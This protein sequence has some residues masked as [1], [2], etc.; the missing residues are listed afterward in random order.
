[1]KLGLLVASL[2]AVLVGCQQKP[3]KI[4]TQ[5]PVIGENITA[6]RLMKDNPVIL[7][8]RPSFEFNLAHVPGAINVRWEDFSQQNP[9][10]RGLLQPDLFALARRLSLIGVDPQTKV[11]VLG[12]GPQG[13][14]EEGRVA[15]TLKVLGVKEVYTVLHTSYREMN[16]TKEAPLVQNKPY[17]K[18]DVAETLTTDFKDF[19][20][21][22]SKVD[23]SVV[24]I[25]VRSAQEYALRNLSQIKDVKASV[26]NVN[27]TEFFG[28]KGLPD[29]KIERALYEKNISKDTKILVISNH[30]V[31][32]GA[33]TYALNFLGYKKASNFAGGYEQWK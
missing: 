14:G 28:E 32:S 29:K 33:V 13:A 26:I 18:P 30:G 12:K 7:D 5:E 1:M 19:K 27:W 17:W 11:L 24:V 4:V 23:N 6:E 16:P 20:N 9:K 10:S 3:T 31:R 15:W 25:D 21:L 2:L 8:A 22:V